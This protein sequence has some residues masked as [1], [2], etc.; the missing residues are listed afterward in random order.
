M[1]QLDE[2]INERL[3]HLWSMLEIFYKEKGHWDGN[4]DYIT[5][6]KNEIEDII[7]E[8]AKESNISLMQ[9]LMSGGA[10]NTDAVDATISA[11]GFYEIYQNSEGGEQ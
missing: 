10:I 6:C 4:Q 8:Y 1:K 2:M 11:E 5:H 7:Q 3:T 9:W